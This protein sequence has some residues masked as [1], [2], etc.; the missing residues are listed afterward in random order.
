MVPKST[1]TLLLNLEAIKRVMVEK[2]NEKLK[3]KGMAGAA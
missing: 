3:A 1:S 2:H